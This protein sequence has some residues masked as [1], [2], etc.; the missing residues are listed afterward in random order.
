MKQH[1]REFFIAM[2]RT[3]NTFI[4]T[5]DCSLVVKPL[6]IDQAYE[7]SD[8]YQQ[9]YQQAYID[10]MMSEEEMNQWM[11]ENNLWTDED[12]ENYHVQKA[13]PKEHDNLHFCRSKK[14]DTRE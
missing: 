12:E 8:V 4:K 14:I 3:G 5:D 13:H 1:E 6:T 9:A 10:G 11:I 7:A 2:I